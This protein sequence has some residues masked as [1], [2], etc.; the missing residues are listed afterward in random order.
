VSSVKA[1]RA[2]LKPSASTPPKLPRMVTTPSPAAPPAEPP[3]PSL[4]PPPLPPPSSGFCRQ[5]AR[6]S[7]VAA[8]APPRT[9]RRVRFGPMV[10][11][12]IDGDGETHARPPPR[13]GHSGPGG[14]AASLLR[15]RLLRGCLLAGRGGGALGGRL[16]GR[17]LRA[18]LG[19]LLDRDLLGDLLDLLGRAQRDVRGAVG[20]VRAEAAVLDHDRLL[21][22]GI[23]A[24]LLERG[25]GG[26]PAPGLGLGV[27]LLRLLQGD[28]EDL[29]LALERARVRAL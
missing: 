29:V 25:L 15:G 5:P 17:P 19:E 9:V 26:G 14:V 6:P 21:A 27:D 16:L 20:D 11:S 28:R 12:F 23:R 8:V 22:G 18:L 3:P 13:T 1:A 7:A 24:E 2:A 10:C 4:P